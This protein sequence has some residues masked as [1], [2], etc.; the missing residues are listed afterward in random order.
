[1]VEEAGRHGIAPGH[2]AKTVARP[3]AS[4]PKLLGEFYWVTASKGMRL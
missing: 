1:V 2:I 4:L 3:G